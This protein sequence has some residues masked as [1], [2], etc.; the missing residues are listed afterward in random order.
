MPASRRTAGTER[1]LIGSGRYPGMTQLHQAVP[2]VER[3]HALI[4]EMRARA[5][6]FVTGR[7]LAE[8]TG[9]TVRTVERDVARLR[10]AG[11]PIEVK[12]GASGGYRL[13]VPSPVAPLTFSPGE[14]AALVAS[15]VAL[16]PYTS[17]TAQSALAK[18]VTTFGGQGGIGSTGT[19]D[20]PASRS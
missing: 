15:L 8:R 17:A 4:E 14:I 9:T 7:V 2:L 1:R 16:G 6:R 10:A 3:Q 12:R 18:L 13:A 19:T 20:K 5:P 11:I